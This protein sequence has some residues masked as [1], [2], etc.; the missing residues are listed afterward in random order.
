MGILVLE[1]LEVLQSVEN[2]LFAEM[3]FWTME[4]NVIMGTS[5]GAAQAARLMQ[6][7]IVAHLRAPLRSVGSVAMGLS[8]Q[9]RSATTKIILAVHLGAK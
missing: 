4:K 8:N 5:Q 1:I 9:E 3:E 6:G 2:R 7:T